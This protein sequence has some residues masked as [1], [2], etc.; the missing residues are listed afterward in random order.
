MH[1]QT[2]WTERREVMEIKQ[3]RMLCLLIGLIVLVS[4]RLYQ[5]KNREQK[6]SS[7]S[8]RVYMIQR[9]Q[10]QQ[11]NRDS[12]S[13]YWYFWTD[14]NFRFHPDS[15]LTGQRGRLFMQES[16][17]NMM[18]SKSLSTNVNELS[19]E[20]VQKSTADKRRSLSAPDLWFI[21]LI[22]ILLSMG[23]KFRK[24]FKTFLP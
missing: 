20:K 24:F 12:L 5:N 8:D 19:A 4:C 22:V 10:Q 3:G 6:Q 14:S 23:W 9:R 21:G 7:S 17:S 18:A 13:R 16:K 11:W 2:G 15:G 1:F